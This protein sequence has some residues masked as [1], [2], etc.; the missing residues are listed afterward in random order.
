[1]ADIRIL[2]GQRIVPDVDQA[3]HFAGY[4]KAGLGRD[5]S[6]A[7]CQELV[8]VLRPLMQAK[9]VLAFTDDKVYAILT[10]GEAV[11]RQLDRYE[12]DGD[13]MD[14]LLFNALADTCLM[15][16]EADVLQKLQLICRQKGCGITGRHEP[17]SDIPITAQADAVRET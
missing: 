16:L 8:P 10:L 14:S 12:K 17:G 2:R 13:V 4:Q 3:L 6:L 7:R 11:S 1:M 15:A 5:K 9:A